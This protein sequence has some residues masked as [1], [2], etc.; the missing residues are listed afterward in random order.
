MTEDH[1][2]RCSIHLLGEFFF[3]HFLQAINMFANPFHLCFY[4]HEQ[5]TVELEQSIK[6][7]IS[8]NNLQ[9]VEDSTGNADGE[10]EEN[11]EPSLNLL[12]DTS[13]LLSSSPTFHSLFA[14]TY[15]T[16]I[17]PGMKNMMR[18]P[19]REPFRPSTTSILVISTATTT[20]P[21]STPIAVLI[22]IPL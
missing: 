21:V 1:K 19:N 5:E 22:I 6:Y 11:H 20:A 13:S 10:S 3:I 9:N 16:Y 18:E 17:R 12:A 4:I 15:T 2:V 7:L 8:V 14:I